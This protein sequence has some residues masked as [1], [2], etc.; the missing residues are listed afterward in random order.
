MEAEIKS[1]SDNGTWELVELP[2]AAGNVVKHKARLVAQGY[3]QQFGIDFDEVFA[4]VIS[5]TTF[6]TL[7]AVA[8]KQLIVL[9]QFDGKTAYLHGELE[10]E[11]F[12]RQPPGFVVSGREN[13]VCRLR[14]SIYGL[15][16]SARCWNQTLHEGLLGLQFKQSRF[17]PCLYTRNARKHVVFVLIYVDD[18]VV[19]CKDDVEIA[20]VFQSLRKKFDITNLGKLT[21]F[22]GMEI[23][24][25]DGVYSI[26]LRGYIQKVAERFEMQ[27][28]KPSKTP[29]DC[30]YIQLDDRG[31]KL[32][33]STKYRSLVGALLYIAVHARPD[34]AACTSILGRRVCDPFDADWTAAKR[35]VRYLLGTI[36]WKLQYTGAAGELIGYTDAGR[37]LITVFCWV[38][39]QFHGSAVDNLQ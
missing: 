6:R 12:M 25:M 28:A 2:D 32:P 23:D 16:Q 14:K 8:S 9:H 10:E 11:V 3:T 21:Y 27:N 7:L 17:D 1:H 4:P 26:C 24:R 35:V 30:G 37:Q 34:I 13:L 36:G 39:R 38:V 15:K 22:L 31:Q 29:M 18:I 19:G 33:D 20:K 5:Q